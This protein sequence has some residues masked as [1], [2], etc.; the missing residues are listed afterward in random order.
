M[1]GKKKVHYNTRTYMSSIYRSLL[2]VPLPANIFKQIILAVRKYIYKRMNLYELVDRFFVCFGIHVYLFVRVSSEFSVL[3][4]YSLRAFVI[5]WATLAKELTTFSRV[6]HSVSSKIGPCRFCCDK[7]I[8]IE[9]EIVPN[10]SCRH[11]ILQSH[12]F[13]LTH[14]LTRSLFLSLFH[15][16]FLTLFVNNLSHFV[17]LS[18]V[19]T[20]SSFLLYFLILNLFSTHSLSEVDLVAQTVSYLPLVIVV[21]VLQGHVSKC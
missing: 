21:I 1:P 9:R 4:V 10:E 5:L 11:C 17:P 15:S 2:P 14:T 16:Y 13:S 8:L 7:R 19:Y 6:I 3:W 20:L 12:C 18:L